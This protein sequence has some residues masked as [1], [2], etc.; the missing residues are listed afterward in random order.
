MGY[1]PNIPHLWVGYNP[2]TIHLLTSW[3]IQEPNTRR[4]WLMSYAFPRSS[5]RRRRSSLG[6]TLMVKAGA[7]LVQLQVVEVKA[8]MIPQKPHKGGT[9]KWMWGFPPTSS[10]KK[11]GFPLFSP[12]I[13]GYHYFWKHPNIP[14]IAP[15]EL[16]EGFFKM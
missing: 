3:D 1:N 13:L 2:L 15:F 16:I 7:G 5:Q 4:G 14:K 11:E 8:G 9:P 10:I 12:S 6:D